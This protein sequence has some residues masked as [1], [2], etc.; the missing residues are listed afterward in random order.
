MEENTQTTVSVQR[1]MSALYTPIA[2]IVAGVVIAVGLFFG[3]SHSS[4]KVVDGNG[5]AQA[6]A[7]PVNIKD[8]KTDGEPFIGKSD[9]PVVMAFWSD[10]QCPYCKAVE[11]GGVPQIKITAAMPEII[12]KYVDTGKLKIVFKDF[13]FL[14]SDSTTAGEYARAIWALYPNQYYAWRTAMFKAQDEEGDQG[15][16]NAKTIDQL[17]VGSFP[18]IDDAAV[19]SAVGKNKTEY[20]ALMQKDM[21]EGAKFGVQGTPGFITG[22]K[23]IAGAAQFASFAAAIDPQLK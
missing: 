11:T 14:G 5:T 1:D 2:I 13:P 4:T 18:S 7:I 16:G 9:A 23:I 20:D 21:E 19:K 15:F 3:L 17:I 12:K 6:P 10:F 8:V 22:T